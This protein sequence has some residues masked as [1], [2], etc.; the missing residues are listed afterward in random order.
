MYLKSIEI[1]GFKSFA[2]KTVLDFQSPKDGKNSITA[3]VGPNGSGKSNI[4][5]AIRWVLGEQSMKQLRGK[6]SADIIFAGS[7][8][9]GQMGMASVE[10]IL[11]NKDRRAP[12]EYDELAIGRRLYR[13]GESEYTLNGATV[14]LIDLQIL[15]AKAQFG[16]GSYSV[17]GQGVIDRMILQSVEERKAFFDEASGIKEFQIKRHQ[18]YLKLRRSR[19]HI[20]QAELL[21]QEISPRL[22]SLLRQVKKLEQRQ[23]V[24]AQ[25]LGLQE[26]YYLV[27]A[28]H[29]QTE[30]DV[31][32]SALAETNGEYESLTN[33]LRSIQEE[34]AALAREESRQDVFA[35]LQKTYQE[36]VQKKHELEQERAVLNGRLQIEYSKAGKQEV[37]WLEK[38]IE[39]LERDVRAVEEERDADKKKEEKMEKTLAETQKE[40]Q[41]YDIEKTETKGRLMRLEQE[42]NE[43]VYRQTYRQFTGMKAVEAVLSTRDD[44]GRVWG[45]VGQLGS[46][47]EKFLTALD[48]AAGGRL[49]SLVVA[50]DRVAEACIRYLRTERLGYATFLPL[51]KIRSRPTLSDIERL[52]AVPGVY[53]QAKHLVEFDKKFNDLFSYILGNTLIVED[54]AVA[55]EVGIGKIRMVTLD[56]DVLE[57]SGSMKGGYRK[58]KLGDMSFAQGA[59]LGDGKEEAAYQKEVDALRQSLERLEIDLQKKQDA[60]RA[61]QSDKAL[62]ANTLDLLNRKKQD[63]ETELASLRQER[64]LHTMS[65]KDYDEIMQQ[66]AEQKIDVEKRI[67]K[68]EK[69]RMQAEK[70]IQHFHEEEET[71]RQ[72]VFA[73]QEDM[74][75][76]QQ[77]LNGVVAKRNE[78]QVHVAKLETKLEDL[79]NELY[80]ELRMSLAALLE[81]VE[82]SLSIDE[83][84]HAQQQIHKLKYKL[85]L[86]GGIDEE[87]VGEYEETKER[88]DTLVLQLDDLNKTVKDLEVLIAELDD[89][90]KKKRTKA[91]KA[92]QKEF[93]RYFNMLF[94]GGEADLTEVYET[95][96][97][98]GGDD[99]LDSEVS[100]E[101]GP[102]KKK[103]KEKKMLAG[104]EIKASPPG[105]KIKHIQALSGGERTLTS[106]A[107]VCAILHTN[108][109]PFVV[110]DEVEAAL[111]EA[112]TLRLAKILHELSEHSQF[113]LITHN[114]AT[115][116]AADALYGVTMG[117]D[118]MSKLL[119][120]DISE[121]GAL[122]KTGDVAS[123]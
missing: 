79:E 5:D 52:L 25:L 41:A 77:Q 70:R 100:E 91:F 80:Q 67:E 118:G 109:S 42:M 21:L 75:Q 81:R 6:K 82:L 74:Q 45:T 122:T 29:H 106:I 64:S 105:K 32:Q 15:L 110:L 13:S 23:E 36:I 95:P 54:I 12:I 88:H 119:S 98:E 93:Q 19:E 10:M 43:V 68:I 115:M 27:L 28:K 114:R 44:F 18:A 55:R 107:L 1:H 83:I 47:P 33:S 38:K 99:A 58:K 56:G 90:M 71:K 8:G 57:T 117:N 101:Q 76:K 61:L 7:V 26:Q 65:S 111:D 22:K 35:A 85:S 102:R 72:R 73:L 92:I 14:R 9:K 4:S 59:Y 17:I 2:K 96:E 121:A 60:L 63:I 31:I 16:H 87:I 104:I 116:H 108:P 39:Q 94:E 3:I 86:I 49:A 123:A 20:E 30:I 112:N 11:D 66:V 113:I 103:T 69:E 37:G 40:V 51:N 34:L 89:I 78:A 120:V 24:E 48:A 62:F 53:G 50:D 84:D 97:E 46:V